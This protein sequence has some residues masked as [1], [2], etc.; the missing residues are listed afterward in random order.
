[1]L[2]LAKL[3]YVTLAKIATVNVHTMCVVNGFAVAGGLF[4]AIGHDKLIM[5]SNPK[6][7]FFLDDARL[8]IAISRAICSY[9]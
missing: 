1:M 4:L 9:C 5:T 7:K 2:S 3:L 6:L 8:G